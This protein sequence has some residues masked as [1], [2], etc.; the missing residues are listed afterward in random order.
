[1]HRLTAS[2]VAESILHGDTSST[3][4][5][6]HY[7]NRISKYNNHLHAY[8]FIDKE[9]A[10]SKAKE[11]DRI[12]ADYKKK[13][14]STAELGPLF[15]VP[16]SIKESFA[17]V[18]TATT[19]NYPP[20]K[21]FIATNTS[22]LV[23]RLLDAGAIILGKTNVPTLLA[24]IQT[25]GPLYPTS[26][27]PYDMSRTPGGSTGGGAAALAAGLS[28]LELGSDIGGSIRNPS[29][30]CGLFG[31]KPT[32]NGTT[33][34]GHFPPLPKS[35][36]GRTPGISVLNNT[37]PLARSVAD[38]ERAYHVLYQPD[39]QQLQYMPVQRKHCSSPNLGDYSFAYFDG[40]HGMQA[41]REARYGL[42]KMV[43][44]IAGQGAK[45]EKI[46]LPKPLT[47][48]M[49]KLWARLFGFMMGQ[50]LSWPMRKLFYLSFR[51]A[52]SQSQ[53]PAKEDLKKGLSLNYHVFSEAMAE[54]QQL[55]AEINALLAPYDAILSPTSMG[56]AFPHNPKHA[57]IPLDGEH[58]PYIDYCLPFVVLYNLTG[59]PVL[60]VPSGLSENGLP[61]GVSIAAPH[62][63]EAS[64]FAIGKQLESLGYAFTPPTNFA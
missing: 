62:H 5:T 17:W 16:I 31:L 44:R 1:M 26:N 58:M 37:G 50:N 11:C 30:F 18:G 40:L 54:R 19:L 10:L 12:L 48:R 2:Q 47:E 56:P 39:W 60:T 32:E 53:L 35:V 27:N 3:E 64:L 25:A 63:A 22:V 45:V 52:L 57:P 38:L 7:L 34:D 42:E 59:H 49:F 20:M 51:K 21:N 33:S 9:G 28:T 8:V 6:N 29:N 13:G 43:Q 24:D 36:S 23:Q 46:E 15:G 55:I 41:G 14:L 61:I 4:V